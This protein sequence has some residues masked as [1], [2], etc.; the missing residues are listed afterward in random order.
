MRSAPLGF[1]QR[2]SQVCVSFLTR[3]AKGLLLSHLSQNGL[4]CY[5]AGVTCHTGGWERNFK[6][7]LRVFRARALEPKWHYDSRARAA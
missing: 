2:L 1:S 6:R 4:C 5:F 7:S 3:K